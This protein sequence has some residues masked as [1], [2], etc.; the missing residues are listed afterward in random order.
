MLNMF[1][2]KKPGVNLVE[3]K[4][5]LIKFSDLKTKNRYKWSEPVKQLKLVHIFNK[6]QLDRNLIG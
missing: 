6:N 2:L 1:F 5:M 3:R 4:Q